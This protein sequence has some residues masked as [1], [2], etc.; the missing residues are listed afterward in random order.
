MLSD[1]ALRGY[2]KY[3]VSERTLEDG[4]NLLPAN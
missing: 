3:V 4:L 2:E 1:Q